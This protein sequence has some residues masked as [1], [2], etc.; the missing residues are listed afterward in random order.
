MARILFA[1][2]DGGGNVTPARVLADELTRRGH[3]VRIMGHAAQADSLS[4][5]GYSATRYRSARPF[6]ASRGNSIHALLGVFGDRRMGADVLDEVRSWPADVVVVDCLLFG[7]MEAL[8]DNGVR[9]VVLE[10]L[11]DRFL[12]GT[13]LKGPIG[14]GLRLKRFAP[15]RLLDSAA[16]TLVCTLPALDP[17]PKAAPNTQQIGPLVRG[18][19][20]IPA[21]PTVLVSLSTFGC[22]GMHAVLQHAIDAVAGVGVRGIVTTGPQVDPTALRAPDG[23]DVHPF[24]PHSEVMPHVSMVI[25]HGGHSTAMLA[26]AHD[27]PLVILPCFRLG[28]QPVVGR[29]IQDAG[30]GR[31]CRKG[32]G[33]ERLRQ[34][35]DD[36]LGDTVFRREAA[37]LG[38]EIRRCDAIRVAGDRIEAIDG[39][40][41]H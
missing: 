10:H 22:T 27:L 21:E 40:Q 4:A 8:S 37:K 20:A 32:T 15:T 18:T 34:V 38:A 16:T 23:I 36:V 5:A 14:I 25:G 12:R 39:V 6:E 30:A 3:D 9:Y 2:W 7:V 31:T 11:Y 41:V 29:S 33:P 17:L 19:P 1:T 13:L 35:I 24:L 28:D 26:L